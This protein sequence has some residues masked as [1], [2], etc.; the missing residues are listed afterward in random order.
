MNADLTYDGKKINWRGNGSFNATSGLPGHQ[1]AADA[2]V[3]NSGPIPEGLYYLYLQ[4]KGDARDDNTGQCALKPAWG[5]QT[6]PRGTRAGACEPYWANWGNNRARLE[7]A[8]TTTKNRCAPISRGGF[9]IHDSTKGYSHGCIEV[10]TRIFPLLRRYR[11]ST[12][13]QRLLLSVTYPS[14]GSTYGGTRN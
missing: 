11:N 12:H 9:Y 6:I 4:D 14:G 8:N 1:T 3:P 2:C 10:E 13:K 5:I 7:P